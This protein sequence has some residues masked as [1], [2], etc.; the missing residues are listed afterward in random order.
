[1]QMFGS[2]NQTDTIKPTNIYNEF[3]EFIQSYRDI[4][5]NGDRAATSSY[6]FASPEH[7]SPR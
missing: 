6:E 7:F 3:A 2:Q 4:I 5:N 1:M